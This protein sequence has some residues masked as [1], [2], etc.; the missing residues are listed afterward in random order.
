VAKI[1]DKGLMS[2]EKTLR[3][4]LVAVANGKVTPDKA[5]DSLKDLTYESVG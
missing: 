4:L 3:S 2:D 5:L 1:K